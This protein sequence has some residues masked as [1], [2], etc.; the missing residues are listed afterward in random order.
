MFH[1]CVLLTAGLCICLSGQNSPDQ[2]V[3]ALPDTSAV[4]PCPDPSGKRVYLDV[5][6]HPS[7]RET[8][9]EDTVT[10]G[11]REV[12]RGSDQG[13]TGAAGDTDLWKV[14][15]GIVIGAVL[16]LVAITA[17][18]FC[19]KHRAKAKSSRVRP[20]TEVVYEEIKDSNGEPAREPDGQSVY[21]CT[22]TETANMRMANR[23]S[24]SNKQEIIYSLVQTQAQTGNTSQS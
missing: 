20:A 2:V 23:P 11:H 5:V 8:Q 17:L 13:G 18:R 21:Y 24:T 16:V 15:V 6:T 3:T 7:G 10:A 22:V 12:D 9:P 1:L 14:P 4:L 19:S